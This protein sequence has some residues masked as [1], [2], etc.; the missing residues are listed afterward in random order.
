VVFLVRLVLVDGAVSVDTVVLERAALVALVATVVLVA[1]VAIV[2]L[3]ALVATVVLV[4][5]A[6]YLEQVEPAALQV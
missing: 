3:V 1:L 4:A 2:V 6:D 5:L